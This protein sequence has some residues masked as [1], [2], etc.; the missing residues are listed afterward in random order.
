MSA[1]MDC[2]E[3]SKYFN[4]APVFYLEGRRFNV[5]IFH[6]SREQTDYLFSAI[7]A[8][9]QIHKTAPPNEDI[10]VFM[11]GQ[12]EI[13]ST[14]KT[15]TEMNKTSTDNLPI[16]VL[17]LYAALPHSKQL[18]V[19]KK[20]TDGSRKVILSTNIAETSITI[21]GIK[22]VLDTGM[23]KSKFYTPSNN[24]EILKV[25]KISKS[26]AWQRAGRAGNFKIIS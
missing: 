23:I 4:N 10:L 24:L 6:T 20:T 2:D 1:T 26:Q 19:F 15:L 11:T 17:P 8:V 22:Y 12:E 13:E 5:D 18:K 16:C 25:H 21:Q 3:F 9:F 14:V 7:S